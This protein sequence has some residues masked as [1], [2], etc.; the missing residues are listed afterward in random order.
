MRTILITGGAGFIGSAL[1]E[2]AIRDPEN[3]VVIVD[4]L[5]TGYLS[6]LPDLPKKNWKFIKCDINDFLDISSVMHSFS[7]DYVFN[8]AAVVG[9]QRTQDNPVNVLKDIRGIENILNLS[10]NSGVKRVY[11]SS[12]SEVYGE[13]VDLPQNEETTPLNSRV[14]YAVVKNVGEAFAKSYK[15]EYNLDYT[16]FRFFNTYGPKQSKDFVMSRFISLALNNLDIKIYGDGSQTRTFCFIDDN[17]EATYNNFLS[18]VENENSANDVINI[19]SDI[20]TSILD[21]AHKIIDLSGSR[22]KIVHVPPLPE[23]DMNRRLPDTAKMKILLKRDPIKLEDG[24]RKILE[25][26]M[27]LKIK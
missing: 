4:N 15:K 7:F 18:A 17:I 6:K 3:Y 10:K 20:E 19:G 2:R 12:S 23:G 21:L 24:I 14:P 9:V 13:P 22:S 26:P 1:A 5:S 25:N 11:Y 27:F 16:I 8:Y